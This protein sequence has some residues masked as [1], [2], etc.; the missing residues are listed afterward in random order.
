[1]SYM[2]NSALWVL[3]GFKSM[4]WTQ[5]LC[6]WLNIHMVNDPHINNQAEAGTGNSRKVLSVV[7]GV[8]HSYGC[9]IEGWRW[10]GKAPSRR[11]SQ[12]VQG[13]KVEGVWKARGAIMSCLDAA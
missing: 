7:Y 1:M 2:E 3:V 4:I 10:S 8:R 13:P 5:E 9:C 11:N 6:S 12:Q